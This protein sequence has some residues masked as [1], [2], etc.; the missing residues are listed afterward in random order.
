MGKSNLS[1]KDRHHAFEQS[2]GIT[3]AGLTKLDDG[4]RQ[5][6]SNM[7]NSGTVTG[8]E[9]KQIFGVT[10]LCVLSNLANGAS[11][12]AHIADKIVAYFNGSKD[13]AETNQTMETSLS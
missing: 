7:M 9:L 2:H 4:L 5:Q 6:F 1:H 13:T 12:P 11:G 3:N 10:N 8:K